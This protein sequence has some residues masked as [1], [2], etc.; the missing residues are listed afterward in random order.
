[1]K[2][3]PLP[4]ALPAKAFF[5]GKEARELLGIS[6]RNWATNYARRFSDYRPPDKRVRGV[7]LMV[8]RDEL[9]LALLGD[10]DGLAAKRAA[11]Q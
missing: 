9:A 6:P 11:E 3:A 5:S 1:V 10:W 8:R 7:D 2:T 4:V